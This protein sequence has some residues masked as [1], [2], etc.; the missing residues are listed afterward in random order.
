MSNDMSAM[1]VLLPMDV[2]VEGHPC[3]KKPYTPKDKP[4]TVQLTDTA[5]GWFAYLTRLSWEYL[6]RVL[7]SSKSSP[8]LSPP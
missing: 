4:C 7:R 2:E 6:A 8:V 5:K 1:L 3:K